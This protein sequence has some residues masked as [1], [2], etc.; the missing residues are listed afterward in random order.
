MRNM[1]KILNR[2]GNI[3]AIIL[4][5]MPIV[6]IVSNDK[7]GNYWWILLVFSICYDF[8]MYSNILKSEYI[9]E[10][11]K[12]YNKYI[13]PNKVLNVDISD[14]EHLNIYEKFIEEIINDLKN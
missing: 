1:K 13:K 12:R 2:I 8:Y 10:I 7:I 11:E 9:E 4:M 3:I 5:I 6:I 14:K